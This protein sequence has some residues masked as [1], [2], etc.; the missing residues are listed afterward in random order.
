[1]R[2]TIFQ[3]RQTLIT[4]EW[5]NAVDSTLFDSGLFP[6]SPFSFGAVG[7]GVTNDYQALQNT[8]NSIG[9]TII[10][11]NGNTSA[12]KTIDLGGKTFAISKPLII[13]KSGVRI[14]NGRISAILS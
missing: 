1:M 6:T 14:M 8:I 11:S 4:A 13:S 5:L 3:P 12:I 10:A 7:D 2:N 9:T